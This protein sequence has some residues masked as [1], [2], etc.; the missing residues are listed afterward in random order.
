MENSFANKIS[1]KFALGLY[2]LKRLE[3]ATA[4]SAYVERNDGQY[5]VHYT[6][7]EFHSKTELDMK[8]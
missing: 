1:S 6:Q 3:T 5:L 2:F 4:A 8:M 7:N